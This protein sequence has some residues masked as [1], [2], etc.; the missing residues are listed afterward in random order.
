MA[1]GRALVLFFGY[2]HCPDICPNTMAVL[3]RALGQLGDEAEGVQIAL[4]S[5]DPE[6]DT[7]EILGPYVSA[8]APDALGLRGDLEMTERV[9][10]AYGVRF[11]KEYPEVASVDGDASAAT[12]ERYTVAHS[13]TVFLIDTYGQIRLTHGGVMSPD[14]IAHDL[15][16]LLNERPKSRE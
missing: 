1:Q 2:T 7:P 12:S 10:E 6:R 11:E 15:R 4:V 3:S 14:E 9:A 13:G 16:L 5:V 8:F